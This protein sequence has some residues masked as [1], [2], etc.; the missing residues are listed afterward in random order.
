MRACVACLRAHVCTCTHFRCRLI[1]AG[2]RAAH[3]HRV[4]LRT[5]Q[6]FAASSSCSFFPAGRRRRLLPSFLRAD[7]PRV[8]PPD[9][10]ARLGINV[11]NCCRSRYRISI[12]GTATTIT[13]PG[14]P[15]RSLHAAEGAARKN[16]QEGR[17][18][19]GRTHKSPTLSSLVLSF[20]FF[21]F[22]PAAAFAGG[23]I[24]P[25]GTEAR[26]DR[27]LVRFPN[28]GRSRFCHENQPFLSYRDPVNQL[29]I[30]DCL[31]ATMR[32]KKRD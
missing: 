12:R 30:M 6:R 32:G 8:S 20:L 16:T 28:G 3:T 10:V 25:D 2:R 13:L 22:L 26:V 23:N 19:E 11:I 18:V 27:K 24:L 4:N 15:G 14:E 29:L 5:V 9:G 21:F 17:S 7:R 31:P 1:D